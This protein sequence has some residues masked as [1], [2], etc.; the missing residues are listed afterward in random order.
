MKLCELNDMIAL[1]C[2]ITGINS[3]GVICFKPEATEE[4]KA[5]AQ[6]MMNENLALLETDVLP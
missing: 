4:Q 1:V 3:D 6:A 5:A 2:P